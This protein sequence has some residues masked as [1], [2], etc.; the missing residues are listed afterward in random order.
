MLQRDVAAREQ[1]VSARGVGGTA[2]EGDV[3][4]HVLLKKL[5]A[6]VN[7]MH[8]RLDAFETKGGNNGPGLVGRNGSLGKKVSPERRSASK[9]SKASSADEKVKS[10]PTKRE[11]PSVKEAV[12]EEMEHGRSSSNSGPVPA[13]SLPTSARSNSRTKSPG[14]FTPVS[15]LSQTFLKRKAGDRRKEL[16]QLSASDEGMTSSRALSRQLPALLSLPFSLPSTR[17]FA[18]VVC[19]CV[20]EWRKNLPLIHHFHCR[21]GSST[22]GAHRPGMEL[23]PKQF[24]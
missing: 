5:A 17:S 12:K 9:Q 11:S 20:R 4:V 6:E 8:E 22:G 18:P 24:F 14:R 3:Q 10:G 19:A 2:S 13:V 1:S 16:L 7:L 23:L 21:E 15:N